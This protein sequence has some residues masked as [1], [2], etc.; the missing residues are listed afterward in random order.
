MFKEKH[1]VKDISTA[2]L[3][4]SMGEVLDRVQYTSDCYIVKR[5]GREIGAI[6][7]VDEARKINALQ[8][9]RQGSLKK[10]LKILES[11]KGL[12]SDL[13]EDE[14]VEIANQ[15]V[16]TVRKKRVRKP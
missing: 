10:M 13:S 4:K 12:N 14:V 3:R 15:A 8:R 11:K 5:K 7:P 16:Q 2:E 1:I 6:V 9:E